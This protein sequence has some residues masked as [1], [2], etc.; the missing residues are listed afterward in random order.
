MNPRRPSPAHEAL[1][2]AGRR[3]GRSPRS[4]RTCAAA[5]AKG[6]L[7]RGG[8]AGVMTCVA[9]VRR[10]AARLARRHR[11]TVGQ[12]LWK[13][14]P[15][16]VGAEKVPPLEARAGARRGAAGRARAPRFAQ[17]RA[18][19]VEKAA[20]RVAASR[21]FGPP[22]A[23]ANYA[24]AD[25][26]ELGARAKT[27]AAAC[28]AAAAATVP[29]RARRAFRSR[30]ASATSAASPD[31]RSARFGERPFLS[32]S[33]AGRSDAATAS[34]AACGGEP[35]GARHRGP[36]P[37]PG[38]DVRGGGGGR[39][40]PPPPP[41]CSKGAG[42]SSAGRSH[43]LFRVARIGPRSRRAVIVHVQRA[44]IGDARGGRPGATT[45]AAAVPRA[46]R[47]ALVPREAALAPP[48][49]P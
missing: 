7:G 2:A 44:R 13:K 14:R 32:S 41:R 10:A 39:S 42:A 26:P 40:S 3:R 22:R 21:R 45:S 19:V 49:A 29:R 28:A 20:E 16:N 24:A 9:F 34:T 38:D 12:P 5:F 30:P 15:V 1:R 8:R 25:A 33:V 17:A 43:A 6:G 47:W 35:D 11:C 31:T 46:S 23:A 37:R 48:R 36:R 27:A 18:D 4:R